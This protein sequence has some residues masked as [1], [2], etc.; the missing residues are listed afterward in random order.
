M[1]SIK[2]QRVRVHTKRKK[3]PLSSLSRLFL[4]WIKKRHFLVRRQ[5]PKTHDV[6]CSK[7]MGPN[8]H[9]GSKKRRERKKKGFLFPTRAALYV[10]YA[11]LSLSLSIDNKKKLRRRRR[12]KQSARL[13][14]LR[15]TLAICLCSVASTLGFFAWPFS[16]PSSRGRKAH[17]T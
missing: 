4:F 2:G 13:F 16:S 9:K 8:D 11:P 5:R 1:R 17:P 15:R 6:F 14:L 7:K 10:N 3:K 12:V